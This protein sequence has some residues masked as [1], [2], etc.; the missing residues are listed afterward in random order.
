MQLDHAPKHEIVEIM[1]QMAVYA[2]FPAALNGIAATTEVLKE[3]QE[4]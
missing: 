4:E 3:I 2:G 1:Y